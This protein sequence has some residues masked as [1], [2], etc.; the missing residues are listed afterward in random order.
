MFFHFCHLLFA[1]HRR[2][3]I[4]REQAHVSPLRRI[5]GRGYL[6]SA[7]DARP[8]RLYSLYIHIIGMYS[9]RRRISDICFSLLIIFRA[10]FLK[11]EETLKS[12][13]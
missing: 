10:F 11:F 13:T 9:F 3:Q 7:T 4:F 2:S 5:S 6:E 12:N 1:G 8:C